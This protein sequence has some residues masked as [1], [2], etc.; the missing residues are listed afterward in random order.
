M[1]QEELLKQLVK[2]LMEMNELHQEYQD[3]DTHFVIDSQKN[4]NI[5]TIKVKMFDDKKEF[6]DWVNT[7]ND[8]FFNEIWETVSR[9]DNLHSLDEIYNSKD[10]KKVINTFK[11]TAKK[12]ASEK[13]KELQ[14]FI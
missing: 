3:N 10:Y 9:K 5:L 14:K 4:G 7:I 11:Q 12:L 2:Q 6:E 13:I 1:K 8:D